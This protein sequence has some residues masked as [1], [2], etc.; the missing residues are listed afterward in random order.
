MVAC[1]VQSTRVEDPS[2]PPSGGNPG[3]VSVIVTTRNSGSTL[4]TCLESV[5]RQAY[6]DIELLVVDNSSEDATPEIAKRYADRVADMGPERSAQRNHGA[7]LSR[8]EF[9]LFLDADMELPEAVVADCVSSAPGMDAL[10]I[11]EVTT[12]TS[13]LARTRSIE[14]SSYRGSFLF[15]AARL[16]RRTAFFSLGG[17]DLGLTG[18]EDYDLEARLEESGCRVGHTRVPILH[19]EDDITLSEYLR[20][21]T[22]Y[23]IGH[24]RYVERHPHRARKQFGFERGI[25]YAR[26]LGSSPRALAAVMCLKGMEFF[27]V[28]TAP[29]SRPLRT[30]DVY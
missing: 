1:S 23:A 6:R 26:S 9:L 10:I 12:G 22:Y 25:F 13:W 19:H 16:V 3:L 2:A 8:G 30:R 18:L 27:A 29:S 28:A 17:Y 24:D 4:A 21:R 7:R 11:P 5:R 15:E 14:R 20:K